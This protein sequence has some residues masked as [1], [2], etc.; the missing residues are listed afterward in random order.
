VA[1]IQVVVLLVQSKDATK[2]EA[3]SAA[4]MELSKNLKSSGLRVRADCRT[5]V[6]LVQ[7]R[8]E[9]ERK[10]VPLRLEIGAR[11]LESCTAVAKLR[12]GGEKFTV[13]LNNDATSAVQKALDEARLALKD[14]ARTLKQKLTFHITSREEF[15]ARLRE[16]DPGYLFVPWGGDSADEDRI[17]QETGATLRCY[18]FEQDRLEE[19]QCCP[20]TGKKSIAWAVFAK[21]Y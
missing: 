21:A 12:T 1:P 14:H 15:E 10:G 11:D 3:V 18:P 9:W 20:L 5:E 4:V 19:G 16:R 17:Q 7:R 2:N 8:Y 13:A 6:G